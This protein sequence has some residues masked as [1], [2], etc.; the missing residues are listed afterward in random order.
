MFGVA[1]FMTYYVTTIVDF[2]TVTI[3]VNDSETLWKFLAFTPMIALML[4]G[5]LAVINSLFNS[6]A[7]AVTIIVINIALTI[8]LYNDV[9]GFVSI[10]PKYQQTIEYLYLIA[11]ISS[12]MIL[13]DQVIFRLKNRIPE[14]PKTIEE[15]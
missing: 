3:I 2:K 7:M 13:V 6:R 12:L 1:I 11:L 15:A 9:Y 10:V 14:K 4:A 8:F 5:G